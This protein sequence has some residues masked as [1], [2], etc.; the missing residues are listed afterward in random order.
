[1]A[2]SDPF[3][4]QH[5]VSQTY[6]RSWAIPR[7]S[8][9]PERCWTFSLSHERECGPACLARLDK[10]LTEDNIYTLIGPDGSRDL[11]YERGMFHNLEQ[12]YG[13]LK[14]NFRKPRFLLNNSRRTQLA[15]F[16]AYQALKIPAMLDQ[17]HGNLKALVDRIDERSNPELEKLMIET[18]GKTGQKAPHTV[19]EA[20]ALLSNKFENFII[21]RLE[22]LAKTVRKMKLDLLTFSDAG[23]LITSDCPAIMSIPH[24]GAY[25]STI[26]NQASKLFL[27]LSPELL[28]IF[29]WE[30][31]GVRSGA[32]ADLVQANV[33][34]IRNAKS[35]L[36]GASNKIDPSIFEAART[37]PEASAFTGVR[38]H[39]DPVSAEV[40]QNTP[41]FFE[42]WGPD[43]PKTLHAINP[44]GSIE[45]VKSEKP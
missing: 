23:G 41:L 17:Y 25:Y 15:S 8:G 2:A 7:I 21:P 13:R 18:I 35:I 40:A 39:M 5:T 11:K 22:V 36:I 31:E 29:N 37:A 3:T 4:N 30:T 20:R 14:E 19:S 12:K 43:V 38:G 9:D 6:L 10:L 16:A 33:L 44:D 32:E 1:M 27:P 26:G 34:Q 28:A 42:A 45:P 24:A